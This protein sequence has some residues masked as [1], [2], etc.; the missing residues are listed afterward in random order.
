VLSERSESYKSFWEALSEH[1][2]TYKQNSQ[3]TFR[4]F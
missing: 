1:S 4:E 2:E 3:S